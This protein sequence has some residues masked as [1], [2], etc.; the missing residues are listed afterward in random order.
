MKTDKN[1]Y[2]TTERRNGI[3][4]LLGEANGFDDQIVREIQKCMYNHAGEKNKYCKHY[5]L[6]DICNMLRLRLVK[7][8][9]YLAYRKNTKYYSITM[10]PDNPVSTEKE[11]DDVY[12][13]LEAKLKK[14]FGSYIGCREI[15]SVSPVNDKSLFPHIHAVACSPLITPNEKDLFPLED[16]E[17]MLWHHTKSAAI[18]WFP[19]K[20]KDSHV[21]DLTNYDLTERQKKDITFLT[22]NLSEARKHNMGISKPIFHGVFDLCI[23]ENDSLKSIAR[24]WQVEQSRVGTVA[25]KAK[26]TKVICALFIALKD[27]IG[28]GKARVIIGM[29]SGPDRK[30]FKKYQNEYEIAAYGIIQASNLYEWNK[31]PRKLV[32]IA[33]DHIDKGAIYKAA[34]GI[35]GRTQIGVRLRELGLNTRE[36][37]MFARVAMGKHLKDREKAP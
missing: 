15:K 27:D 10:S 9:F 20:L 2:D 14:M 25:E 35:A 32:Q 21:V 22:H 18:S 6:C 30:R 11:C 12:S 4:R 19:A 23:Y 36:R 37:I 34:A 16:V 13:E 7:S 31:A 29:P 3:I 28:M 1:G 17:K 5:L 26:Y 8:I 33:T 24:N